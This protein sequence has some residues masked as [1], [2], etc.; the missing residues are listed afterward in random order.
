MK[1]LRTKIEAWFD[2][3]DTSWRELPLQQQYRYLMCCFL[4]YVALTI[5][6]A[7]KVWYDLE[8]TNHSL[9]IKHIENP[10]IKK[11]KFDKPLQD[12]L[13][14]NFKNKKYERK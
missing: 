7:L 1:K 5:A 14:N 10:I 12:S 11:S 6:V 3:L 4:I 13:I 9:A 8:K 2:S